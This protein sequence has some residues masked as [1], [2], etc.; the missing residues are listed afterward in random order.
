MN[1]VEGNISTISDSITTL[2]NT[3]NN[4]FTVKQTKTA[5]STSASTSA[6]ANW[7]NVNFDFDITQYNFVYILGTLVGQLIPIDILQNQVDN[8][9]TNLCS[10]LYDSTGNGTAGYRG[11]FRVKYVSITTLSVKY[12]EVKGYKSN[13]SYGSDFTVNF[14]FI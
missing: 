12:T 4:L 3:V 8:I 13:E 9:V 11:V 1:T 14:Y 2:T 6:T 7:F 10:S 5:V